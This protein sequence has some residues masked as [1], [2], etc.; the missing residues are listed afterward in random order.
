MD[1]GQVA[2][3]MI[4]A[5]LFFVAMGIP[6]FAA[7][8]GVALFF[9]LS[10]WG[11]SVLP[12]ASVRVYGFIT[13]PSF[14]AVPMFVLMGT[15]LGGSGVA[16]IL[17]FGIY[18]LFGP[19]RGGLL[20]TVGL[21]CTL[22]AACTGIAAGPVAIMGLIALPI[23]LR[24][25][26]DHGL[27]T[28]CIS[29]SATLGTIIPPSVLIIIYAMQAEMSVG[30]LYFSA[31][32]PGFLL[33]ALFIVYYLVRTNLMSPRMAPAASP[34]ERTGSIKE[35]LKLAIIGVLPIITL[36]SAVLGTIF[37]GIATPTEAAGMGAFGALIISIIYRKFTWRGFGVALTNCLRVTAMIGG[38]TIG[39]NFFSAVFLAAG[40]GKTTAGI[41]L[42]MGLGLTGIIFGVL[43]IDFILGFV[44]NNLSIVLILVPIFHPMVVS[45]GADPH[46]FAILFVLMGQIAYLTPPFA[47]GVYLLK[48]LCPKE[49]YLTEMYKGVIPFIIIDWIC[50]VIVFLYKPLTTWLPSLMIKSAAR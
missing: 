5:M 30:R 36:I 10:F 18:R 37:A 12:I 17:F 41:L 34:E 14:I 2:L 29:A 16:E 47:P 15:I 40:G 33:S 23:M 8:G 45:M 22:L 25:K 46:W 4:P 32:M 9:G 31:F 7:M 35:S 6:F 11:W 39:A 48:P 27:A 21:I 13:S 43:F 20:I 24:R 38:I 44:M 42:G 50:V 1:K 26:Y 49:I 3:F 19:I 28:A